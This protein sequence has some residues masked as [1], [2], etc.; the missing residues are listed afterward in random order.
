MKVRVTF[1]G[2][3]AEYAS[4]P[5]LDL[6]MGEGT[7]VRDLLREVGS[8]FSGRW[9]KEV[10]DAHQSRFGPMVGVFLDEREVEDED[11]RLHDGSE[12]ILLPMMA[13][14]QR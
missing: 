12:V 1:L 9:P 14:G 7:S 13:G 5:Y 4:L 6:E 3:L 2:I 10:W 8:Q 11:A